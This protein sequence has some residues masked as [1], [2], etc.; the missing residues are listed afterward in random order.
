EMDYTHRDPKA[1]D[2]FADNLSGLLKQLT[3]RFAPEA[4]GKKQYIKA[5]HIRSRGGWG[6]FLWRGCLIEH[7]Y[8]LL[9]YRNDYVHIKSKPFHSDGKTTDEWEIP[10]HVLSSLESGETLGQVTVLIVRELLEWYLPW[11]EQVY[12]KWSGRSAAGGTP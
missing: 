4:D 7:L 6:A 11:H 12:L 2:G 1:S 10:D 3:S 8:T 9:N 5:S